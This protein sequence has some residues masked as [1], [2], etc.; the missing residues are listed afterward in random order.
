[1]G[2][3]QFSLKNSGYSSYSRRRKRKFLRILP[4]IILGSILAILLCIAGY[5]Y[6]RNKSL[7]ARGASIAE[8]LTGANPSRPADSDNP[9]NH[10]LRS[11]LLRT[12]TAKAWK[13]TCHG[14]VFWPQ[15]TTM[16]ALSPC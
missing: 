12:R 1:M 11:L 13:V 14:Q 15:D 10:P 5:L 4:Y 9:G 3:D 8:V 2:K 7:E 6:M 16:T